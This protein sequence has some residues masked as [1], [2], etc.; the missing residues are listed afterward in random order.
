[1]E[2]GSVL[3]ATAISRQ[4]ARSVVLVV[5]GRHVSA[6]SLLRKRNG[7]VSLP[8]MRDEGGEVNGAAAGPMSA[9][10]RKAGRALRHLERAAFPCEHHFELG[11]NLLG[12]WQRVAFCPCGPGDGA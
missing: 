11:R 12:C 3:S 10:G 2:G 7:A 5:P 9:M 4:L 1:M 8:A 6:L